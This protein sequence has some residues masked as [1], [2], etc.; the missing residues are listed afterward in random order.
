MIRKNDPNLPLLLLAADALGDLKD[1]FVFVGGCAA[2]LLL[3][4][5][6]AEDIRA[7]TDVDVV[8]ELASL[9]A[10]QKLGDKLQQRGFKPDEQSTAICAW[11]YTEKSTGLQVKLDVMPTDASVLGF[12][13]RWYPHAIAAAVTVDLRTDLKIR[14]ISGPCFLATKLEAFR[15]RGKHDFLMSH[16]LEDILIVV[17]GRPELP[18]E[19]RSADPE[20]AAFVAAQFQG[21]LSDHDFLNAVPGLLRDEGRESIVTDRMEKICRRER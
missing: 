7:T 15:S 20:L 18:D 10:Y 8:V 14:L 3:T 9:V 1:Q 21:L 17:D 16:D 5:P 6:A 19:M 12:S 13:N 11:R 2:G 4:D